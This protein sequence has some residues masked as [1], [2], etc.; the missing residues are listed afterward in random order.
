MKIKT[1]TIQESAAKAINRQV[2]SAHWY[3]PD[4]TPEY[5]QIIKTGPNKGKERS[6]SLADARKF[7]LFPSITS[8]EKVLANRMLENYLK[9]HLLTAAYNTTPREG[10][11][12]E[13]YFSRVLEQSEKDSLEAA[14][15]GTNYHDELEKI[16][17]GRSDWDTSDPKLQIA[18]HWIKK[19]VDD[20]IWTEKVIVDE[21][22]AVAGK[23]D[24]LLIVNGRR[25]II[26]WKSRRFAYD[27]KKGEWVCRWYSSDCRQLSFYAR[28]WYRQENE[29][30]QVMNIGMNT[31]A[32]SELQTKVWG[33]TERHK[34]LKAVEAINFI[35][36][37]DRD[38]YPNQGN[39]MPV[40]E[41]VYGK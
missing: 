1:S 29:C 35:W 8:I 18:E 31:N 19:N 5:T 22:M 30:V 6:T 7:S 9:K 17:H 15:K 12:A 41:E 38:Y 24:G 16:L 14:N 32:D 20:V 11:A 37:Y 23:S 34:A 39:I 36:Q 33:D 28:A 40:I 21:K 3:R 2:D 10:E 27:E 4:G 13:M 25:T 26:D